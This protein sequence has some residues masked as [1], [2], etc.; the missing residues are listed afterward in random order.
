M[1]ST[2]ILKLF[3]NLPKKDIESLLLQKA[4]GKAMNYLKI[5]AIFRFNFTE[6]LLLKTLLDLRFHKQ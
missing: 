3:V 5:K 1:K 2:T 4:I 6:L